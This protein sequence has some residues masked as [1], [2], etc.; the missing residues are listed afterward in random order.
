MARSF[1]LP[2]APSTY[3]RLFRERI[4][5]VRLPFGRELLPRRLVHRP[6]KGS[7][8]VSFRSGLPAYFQLV[9]LLPH[10]LLRE[11]VAPVHAPV[12]RLVL[13]LGV[14]LINGGSPYNAY[15]LRLSRGSRNQRRGWRRGR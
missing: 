6:L 15:P 5:I 11:R 3:E 2:G 14:S 1:F 12:G 13:A 9:W 10:R 8:H 4:D 7:L